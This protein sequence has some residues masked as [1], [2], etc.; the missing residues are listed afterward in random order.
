MT[1]IAV[2]F[3]H[4]TLHLQKPENKSKLDENPGYVL[5]RW[6]LYGYSK[7]AT[8]GECTAPMPEA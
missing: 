6:K 7:Q 1:S 8:L 2:Q 5:N 3:R 4:A